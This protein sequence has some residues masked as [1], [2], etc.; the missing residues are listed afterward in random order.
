MD[1][2]VRSEVLAGKCL[3]LAKEI[4]SLRCQSTDLFPG[5]G[6]PTLEFGDEWKDYNEKALLLFSE[7]TELVNRANNYVDNIYLALEQPD[8]EQVYQFNQDWLA[9]M[10]QPT[11]WVQSEHDCPYE[12]GG[13]LQ[14]REE[15]DAED[16]Q[17]IA[18]DSG[19]EDG[20][21]SDE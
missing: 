14:P 2:R 3:E 20:G 9:Q 1:T 4:K 11:C 8:T 5:N 6:F 7:T 13:M 12:C 19:A 10:E 16:E 15:Y 21:V 17:E 18:S